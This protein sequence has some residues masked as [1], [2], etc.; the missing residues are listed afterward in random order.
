M[1]SFISSVITLALV[2]DG[3]GNIPLFIAGDLD[4]GASNMITDG[5]ACGHQMQIGATGDPEP[6]LMPERHSK[7]DSDRRRSHAVQNEGADR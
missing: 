6:P 3:F 4:R 7:W 1:D 5:T 2:M